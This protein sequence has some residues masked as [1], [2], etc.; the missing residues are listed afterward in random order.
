[1]MRARFILAFAAA[2]AVFLAVTGVAGRTAVAA[3]CPSTV[4][5]ESCSAPVRPV[6]PPAG[7]EQCLM[8][9]V[10]CEEAFAASPDPSVER[11]PLHCLATAMEAIADEVPHPPPKL[12]AG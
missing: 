6:L 7:P 11:L 10:G 12:A 5:L 9:A 3:P 1:M 2:I 4:T 8:K